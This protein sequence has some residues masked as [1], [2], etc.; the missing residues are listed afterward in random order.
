[1]R[2]SLTI[3]T[4][5]KPTLWHTLRSLERQT[6]KPYEV[7]VINQGEPGLASR[8]DFDLPLRVVD[9]D[10]KGLSR[11]R[12]CAIREFGGDWLM[13]LDDDEEANA[14]WVEALRVTVAAYPEVDFAGGPYLPPVRHNPKQSWVATYYVHGEVI[15]DRSNLLTPTGV[16]GTGFDVWGGNYAISRKLI[17]TVGL[18]DEFM[19]RGSGVVDM[20]EDTDYFLRAVSAGFVGVITARMIIVH[21]YGAR[22]YSAQLAQ[23]DVESNA[24]LVWKSG[25]AEGRIDPELAARCIPF[26]K[27]RA[28]LGRLSRGAIFLS[29]WE[30]KRL[31]DETMTRLDS[32][33]LVRDGV[34]VRKD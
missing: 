24:A 27:K 30:R 26:G 4:L 33:F 18:F 3:P 17:E 29:Q 32:G 31:F 6:E 15:L 34:M 9:Q 25:Q 22:P 19:G 10:V 20:G 5:G 1:M 13:T 21:S 14:E 2:I 7:L 28:L 11:A 12:N 16:P 23:D 8:L